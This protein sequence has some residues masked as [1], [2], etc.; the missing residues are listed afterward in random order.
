[1]ERKILIEIEEPD[2]MDLV[3]SEEKEELKSTVAEAIRLR[4]FDLFVREMKRI[5]EERYNLS[6][7]IHTTCSRKEV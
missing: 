1:M 5:V 3:N 4:V 2:F 7:Q 6:P